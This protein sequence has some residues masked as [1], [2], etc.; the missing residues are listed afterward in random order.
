MLFNIYINSL[1]GALRCSDFGCHLGDEYIGCIV[2]ADDIILLSASLVKLQNMLD[3]CCIQGA[4]LDIQF[5][6]DKSYLFVVGESYGEVLP[7]LRI[8]GAPIVWA[9]SLRYLNVK[10]VSDKRLNIDISQVMRKFYAAA[11]A[12]FSHCKYA[13]EF[14]KLLL[15]E[16]FTLPMLT[17]GLNAIFLSRTQMLKL[18][19]CW[20]NIY[21]KIFGHFK[22]ESVKEIQLFCQR[23][24]FIR[25][26][27]KCK[28]SF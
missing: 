26:V 23:L 6:A 5:N 21:R 4:S 13:S 14:T 28:F 17:Y 12:I 16:S 1:I 7:A 20:N 22:W 8:N 19:S 11:N 3:I 2:Y 27:D 10:F 15:L 25:V 24:D 18:N 9:N